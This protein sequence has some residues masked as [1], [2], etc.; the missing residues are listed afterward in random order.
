MNIF[1]GHL[2]TNQVFPYPQCL[3]EEQEETLKMM[4]DPIEKFFEVCQF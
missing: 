4:I 1:R 3:N 2:Q